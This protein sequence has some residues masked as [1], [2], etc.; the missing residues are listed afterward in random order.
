MIVQQGVLDSMDVSAG[1]SRE[2]KIPFQPLENKS[3]KEQWLRLSVHET[4]D[5]LW[6]RAGFEIAKQQ[7][8]LNEGHPV[9]A[10]PGRSLS[11]KEDKTSIQLNGSG[12]AAVIDRST[13]ELSSYKVGGEEWIKSPLRPAFWRP[14]TDNDA[15]GGKTQKLMKYWK[16]LGGKLT[17]DSVRMERV[18]ETTAKVV[19]K[20]RAEKT[21]LV[22]TYIFNGNGEVS[23]TMDLD[24]DPTLP[25]MPRLGFSMGVSDEFVTTHYFGKGPWENYIDR[26]AGAEVGLYEK[27]TA[28]MYFEYAMPQENGNHTATRWVD[29]AGASGTLHIEG[30]QTF[31]FS[32][33]PWSPENLESAKHPF[34]LVEQG[35]YTVNIDHKQMGVGGTDSWSAK[36][37][38]LEHYRIP[39]GKYNYTVRLTPLH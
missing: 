4:H 15:K 2:I 25:P 10:R 13:G 22:I 28:D 5:K 16:E 17:T 7:F 3:G 32:I 21:D 19:V 8:L 18:S 39:S 23:V 6:C 9:S 14:Q 36:A 34:D 1:Q 27:P 12:F 20:K 30:D 38:P 31:G 33:W 35:F 11:I 26:C 37:L 29:L 24:S